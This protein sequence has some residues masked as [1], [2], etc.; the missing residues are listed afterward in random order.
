[1]DFVKN[2]DG[3]VISE[4]HLLDN[5]LYA[6]RYIASLWTTSSMSHTGE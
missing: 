4:N 3:A 1:M 6:N 2:A 5:I